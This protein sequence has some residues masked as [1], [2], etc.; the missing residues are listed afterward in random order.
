MLLLAEG[1][2]E[3]NRLGEGDPKIDGVLQRSAIQDELLARVRSLLPDVKHLQKVL[4]V[5]ARDVDLRS[6]IVSQLREEGFLVLATAEGAAALDMARDNPVCLVIIDR[7]SLQPDGLNLCRR[8]RECDQTA[9]IPQL[10]LVT[11]DIEI[12]QI[13][14]AGPRVDDFLLK[15]V[16]PAEL[17]ACVFALL[18]L[19]RR[20]RKKKPA[21]AAGSP[22]RP[23][24]L[25]GG[26][27]VLVAED[28]RVDVGRHLVT[29]G[30]REISLGKSLL[31]D[32]LVYLLRHRGTALTREQILQGVWGSEPA[33][34]TR[35]VDVH[36][37]WLRQK[38]QDDPV[39]PQL[40]QTVPGVGYRFKDTRESGS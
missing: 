21:F 11:D 27:Q 29:Q 2:T 9:S 35:T 16:V 24:A 18:R 10:L 19:D 39:D 30:S 36:V 14:H 4:L 17:H 20:T 28:L 1:A 6:G 32:L 38:L 31:F 7:P 25:A 15:P 40:I 37:H 26:G 22:R 13:A 8:L 34:E 33:N 23:T 5:A 12:A 3:A